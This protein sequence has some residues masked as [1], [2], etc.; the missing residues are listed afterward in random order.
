MSFNVILVTSFV[1][2][3]EIG[4]DVEGFGQQAVE[5]LDVRYRWVHRKFSMLARTLLFDFLR[6]D[7]LFS[8]I[9]VFNFI[10]R[11][12]HLDL[13]ANSILRKHSRHCCLNIEEFLRNHFFILPFF[14]F[15][16]KTSLRV[17]GGGGL[18]MGLGVHSGNGG[19]G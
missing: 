17:T 14:I 7:F 2:Y 4:F 5:D 10:E 18:V 16:H 19:F 6:K 11:L 13:N 15:I 8:N 3:R 1:S 9:W 12:T